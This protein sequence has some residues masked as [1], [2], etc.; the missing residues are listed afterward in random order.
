LENTQIKLAER[1]PSPS[2]KIERIFEG[3]DCQLA[4]LENQSYA[5]FP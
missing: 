2:E 1:S 4:I 3:L 5:G